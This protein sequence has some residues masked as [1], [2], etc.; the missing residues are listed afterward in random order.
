MH[1][2]QHSD[3]YERDVLYVKEIALMLLIMI[4]PEGMF[5]GF[6]GSQWAH[7]AVVLNVLFSLSLEQIL[8]CPCAGMCLEK[9]ENICL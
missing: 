6:G 3:E 8:H 9:G 1:Q 4:L 2:Q 5:D 7:R